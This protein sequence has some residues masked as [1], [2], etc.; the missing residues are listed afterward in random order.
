LSSGENRGKQVRG[1]RFK[2]CGNKTK[3][4][5]LTLV[6]ALALALFAPSSRV[7]WAQNLFNTTYFDLSANRFYAGG[8]GSGKQ[9]APGEFVPSGDPQ[10]VDNQIRLTNPTFH[11]NSIANT[12]GSAFDQGG[13]CAMIYV[14]DDDESLVS[15]CGCPITNN[16]TITLSVAK[17]LTSNT[18]QHTFPAHGIIEIFSALP[19]A[20]SVVNGSP[21]NPCNPGATYTLAPTVRSWIT[22][23]VSAQDTSAQALY[24]ATEVEFL[25]AYPDPAK[26]GA[27]TTTASTFCGV[28]GKSACTCGDDDVPGVVDTGGVVVAP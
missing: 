7:A 9:N 4:I 25:W 23:A 2:M 5:M 10:Y 20:P 28:S 1:G 17:D 18:H 16:G 6:I 19:N 27:L 26:Q 8:Y 14:T 24:N 21:S 12:D 22:H 3:G 13:L 11:V 15:C